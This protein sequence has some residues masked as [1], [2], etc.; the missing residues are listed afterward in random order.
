MVA[1]KPLIYRAS[2]TDDFY[3]TIKDGRITYA[4]KGQE[5]LQK[6]IETDEGSYYLGEIALVSNKSPLS[7]LSSTI[8]CLM[9]IQPAI[10][11]LEMRLLPTFKIAATYLRKS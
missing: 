11:G 4:V 2:V 6:L 8:L 7:L 1:T 3:L 5:V 9:K 10:L